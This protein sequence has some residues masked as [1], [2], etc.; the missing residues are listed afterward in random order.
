MH[1]KRTTFVILILGA[2]FFVVWDWVSCQGMCGAAQQ[3]ASLYIFL[4][5]FG[6]TVIFLYYTLK[7]W[8]GYKKKFIEKK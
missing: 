3:Q 7:L 1:W 4:L 5:I 2:L 8:A 6:F